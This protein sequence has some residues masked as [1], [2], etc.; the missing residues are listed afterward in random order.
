MKERVEERRSIPG[1]KMGEK[2]KITP[3]RWNNTIPILQQQYKKKVP[4]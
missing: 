4:S 1:M 2:S 3:E